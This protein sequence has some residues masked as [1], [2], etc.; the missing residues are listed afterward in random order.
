MHKDQAATSLAKLCPPRL[1]DSGASSLKLV[2]SGCSRSLNEQR[3]ELPSCLRDC[4]NTAIY[5]DLSAQVH[6]EWLPIAAHTLRVVFAIGSRHVGINQTIPFTPKDIN[7]GWTLE[8]DGLGDGS[9]P[10]VRIV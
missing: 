3:A 10:R 8:S 7:I 2:R 6:P 9:R 5:K 1:M 4:L